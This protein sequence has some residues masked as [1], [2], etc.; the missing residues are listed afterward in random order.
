MENHQIMLS[1]IQA[2]EHSICLASQAVG[3]KGSKR[4]KMLIRYDAGGEAFVTYQ[5]TKNQRIADGATYGFSDAAAAVG[6]Y[7]RT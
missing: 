2:G 1:D 3:G 4:L 5:V 6:C 7:N